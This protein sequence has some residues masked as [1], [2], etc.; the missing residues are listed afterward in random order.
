MTERTS[1]TNVGLLKLFKRHN[2]PWMDRRVR[3]IKLSMVYAGLD[4]V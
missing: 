3:S 4:G 2:N 1:N